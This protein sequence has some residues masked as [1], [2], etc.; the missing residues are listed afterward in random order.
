MP[1][2]AGR[3]PLSGARVKPTEDTNLHGES[4]RGTEYRVL[5][6]F[7]AGLPPETAPL[8]ASVSSISGQTGPADCVCPLARPLA[9][10]NSS[11]WLF[12]F[13]S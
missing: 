9:R 4:P 10:L 6:G 12:P 2:P 13:S 1:L 5:A 8:P 11:V 3:S 7:T